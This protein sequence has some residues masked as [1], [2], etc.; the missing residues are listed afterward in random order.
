MTDVD[1]QHK[2]PAGVPAEVKAAELT[3]RLRGLC[4]SFPPPHRTPVENT[5]ECLRSFGADWL[6]ALNECCAAVAEQMDDTTRLEA[7]RAVIGSWYDA[8]LFPWKP[9]LEIVQ[10]DWPTWG[11]PWY[12]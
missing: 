8:R 10:R 1:F 6:T 12:R 11:L 7:V 5:V 4:R 9:T 2:P 3:A